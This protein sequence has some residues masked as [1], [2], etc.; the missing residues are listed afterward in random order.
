ML[1]HKLSWHAQA[2]YAT[3]KTLKSLLV[4]KRAEG[5]NG[6]KTKLDLSAKYYSHQT[7]C[8][9]LSIALVAQNKQYWNQTFT[10]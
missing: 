7:H 1:G 5:K 9:L 2:I 3:N 8:S 4:C 6:V 10:E